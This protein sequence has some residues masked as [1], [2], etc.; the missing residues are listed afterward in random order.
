MSGLDGVEKG[1]GDADDF[2][3][4]NG[5]GD[6]GAECTDGVEREVVRCTPSAVS[7]MSS[8]NCAHKW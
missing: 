4:V 8:C 3:F 1:E 7:K 2:V 5:T 6:L